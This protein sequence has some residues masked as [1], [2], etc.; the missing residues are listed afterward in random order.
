MVVRKRKKMTPLVVGEDGATGQLLFD[1]QP[2]D[3]YLPQS[4]SIRQVNIA[5]APALNIALPLVLIF[6][7]H[8]WIG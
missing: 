2:T 1:N 6:T 7:M 5:I 4:N 3:T 8:R